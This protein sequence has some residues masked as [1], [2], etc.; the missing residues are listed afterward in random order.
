[1][2]ALVSGDYGNKGGES[3]E[4]GVGK[5]KKEHDQQVSDEE[6]KALWNA[7]YSESIHLVGQ[8]TGFVEGEKYRRMSKR[9]KMERESMNPINFLFES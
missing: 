6:L 5:N 1:M 3:T 7:C 9:R 4:E 2:K 8:A